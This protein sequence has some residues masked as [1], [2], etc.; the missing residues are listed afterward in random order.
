MNSQFN[1]ASVIWMF[2]HKKDYLKIEKNP[3]QTFY[4]SSESYGELLSCSNE[5][6]IHQKKALCLQIYIKV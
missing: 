4:Y 1:H 6:S 2:F 5:V 3:M